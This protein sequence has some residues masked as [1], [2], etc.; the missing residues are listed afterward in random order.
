MEGFMLLHFQKYNI[1]K[2]TKFSTKKNMNDTNISV[3]SVLEIT[4]CRSF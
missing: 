3:N 2:C 1:F 4:L